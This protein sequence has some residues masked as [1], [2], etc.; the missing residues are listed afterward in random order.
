MIKNIVFDLGAVLVT[1]NPEKYLKQYGW[2][3][4]TN[5]ELKKII[6]NSEEWEEC[7]RGK[8]KNN[9]DLVKV[10]CDSNPAYADKIRLVLNKNWV[11]LL[12]LKEDTA[13]FLK[14][15]KQKGFKIYV[16]SNLSE[17]SYE[18]IKNYD[19]WEHVDGGV[20][21]YLEK[22]CKPDLRIY[23]ILLQRYELVP[24]ETIF[25]DDVEKNIEAAEKIGMHGIIFQQLERVKREVEDLTN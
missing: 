19:F 5:Q 6:F 8:Y 14:E 20:F 1:F 21:S 12:C 11:K 9:S 18:F 22:M 7:D 23:E 3:E 25:I 15:L 17:E 2:D 13:D 10:L 24:G 16:L 4:N